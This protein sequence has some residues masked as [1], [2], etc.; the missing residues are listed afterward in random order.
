M[1]WIA[2]Q[3]LPEPFLPEGDP[4]QAMPKT[5]AT[6]AG[7]RAPV[8]VDALADDLTALGWWALQFTPK[9]ARVEDVLVLEVLASER[10]FGGRKQLLHQIYQS[11]KPVAPVRYTRKAT[12]LIAIARLQT[13]LSAPSASTSSRLSANASARRKPTILRDGLHDHL[14]DSL[15][16]SLPLATLSEARPRWKPPCCPVPVPACCPTMCARVTACTTCW[17]A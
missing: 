16:H 5:Q 14:P 12:Y 6:S 11:N 10:L 13:E 1:H 8:L 3:P 7:S 4:G 9:V 2:L 15:P 17:S